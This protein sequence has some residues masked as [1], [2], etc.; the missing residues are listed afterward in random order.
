MTGDGVDE[1]KLELEQ[2]YI[3][4]EPA[5]RN[6]PRRRSRAQGGGGNPRGA[7]EPQ[8]ILSGAVDALHEVAVDIRREAAITGK[9]R[10]ASASRSSSTPA[11][12]PEAATV[13]DNEEGAEEDGT[14]GKEC[15][16]CCD[17]PKDT[18]LAPCGHVATCLECAQTLQ[19]RKQ[20]CPICRG[21]I[22]RVFRVF[23][24]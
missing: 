15:V 12:A 20:N 8:L 17:K 19:R 21:Y 16:I 11:K 22:D 5:P 3:E 10:R 4:Q 18:L 23:Q 13:E 2:A 9:P 7:G 14:T 24:T 1:V 6:K